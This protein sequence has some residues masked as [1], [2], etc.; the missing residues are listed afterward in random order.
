MI[1]EKLDFFEIPSKLLEKVLLE[2]HPSQLL[3]QSILVSTQDINPENFHN[4]PLSRR[5]RLKGLFFCNL[6]LLNGNELDYIGLDWFGV[7]WMDL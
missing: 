6:P 3:M 5:G 2:I 7:D 4:S 1:S